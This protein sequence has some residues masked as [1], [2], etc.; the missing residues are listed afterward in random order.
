MS[1]LSVNINSENS[2]FPVTKVSKKDMC[3]SLSVL[4]VKGIFGSIESRVS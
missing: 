1:R 4:L 2:I 3:H